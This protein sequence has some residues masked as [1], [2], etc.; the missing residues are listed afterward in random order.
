VLALFALELHVEGIAKR[1]PQEVECGAPRAL[2]AGQCLAGVGGQEPRDVLGARE[3]RL[4]E[5]D[6]LEEAREA[7]SLRAGGAAG[8]GG[9]FPEGGFVFREVVSFELPLLALGV[10][11]HQQEV[12][13]VRD[14]DQ[15]VASPIARDLLAVG[16][17]PGVVADGL[18][19]DD[20][21]LGELAFKRAGFAEGLVLVR[22]VEA[23]VGMPRAG[24][25]DLRNGADLGVERRTDRVEQAL[26]GPVIGFLRHAG[27]GGAYLPQVLQV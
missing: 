23:V 22:G 14:E 3:Q 1:L 15:A 8:M 4:V 5:Q 12:A 11:A 10:A 27:A 17:E 24:V 20:S 21:A 25:G 2:H 6:A 19:L 9:K 7:L 18:D 13:E 26:Q 16:R